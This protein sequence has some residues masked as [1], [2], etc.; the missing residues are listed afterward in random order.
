MELIKQEDNNMNW[1][2]IS[3]SVNV[4][5]GAKTVRYASGTGYNIE[6]RKRPIPHANGGGY[7]GAKYWMYTSYYLIRPDG[8]EKEYHSL[9]DA[10][11]AAEK[12]AGA[13]E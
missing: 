12:E 2:K 6:S 7:N 13:D 1:T 10:K 5:T 8:T 4:S 3:T 11:A 9:K